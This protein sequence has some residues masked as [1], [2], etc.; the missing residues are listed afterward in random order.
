M[1]ACSP[2]PANFWSA[3]AT[4]FL[5]F[6]A[7]RIS[8]PHAAQSS[9]LAVRENPVAHCAGSC[10]SFMTRSKSPS[11]MKKPATA[12]LVCPFS[13]FIP[14]DANE[15][16]FVRP[17]A[18]SFEAPAMS[19][20]GIVEV[21]VSETSVDATC[22]SLPSAPLVVRT[23]VSTCSCEFEPISI[24]ATLSLPPK[25]LSPVN[26][27]FVALTLPCSSYSTESSF[28]IDPPLASA[29]SPGPALRP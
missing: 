27:L 18:S 8:A 24:G 15:V 14:P 19:N 26:L 11:S 23:L 13:A 29:A 2:P 5:S 10:A 20:D 4:S 21:S 9:M 17:S 22:T 16:G 6:L 7:A 25:W 12:V 3:A 28:N 1:R